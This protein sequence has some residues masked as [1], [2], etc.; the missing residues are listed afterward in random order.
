[1]NTPKN[2]TIHI[3]VQKKVQFI[4]KYPC[5]IQQLIQFT[6]IRQKDMVN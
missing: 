5:F 2:N 3:N 1:M 4:Q 6:L